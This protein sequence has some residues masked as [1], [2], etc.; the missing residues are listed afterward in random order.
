MATTDGR[1]TKLSTG[2]DMPLVGLGTWLAKD[3]VALC[4]AIHA[5]IDAGYRLFDTAYLYQ[6]EEGVGEGLAQCIKHGKIRREDIFV[7]TKVAFCH[8][9]PIFYYGFSLISLFYFF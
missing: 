8:F 1:T 9:R 3:K 4:S 7:T 6:T 2:A 5:A